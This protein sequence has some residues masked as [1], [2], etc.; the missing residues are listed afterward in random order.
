[1]IPVNTPLFSGN[2]EIYLRECIQTGWVS[3]E[4]P[5]VKQFEEKFASYIGVKHGISVCNGTAA[6]EV[7]LDSIG[8]TAGD[9]VIMPSSTIMSCALACIRLGA[10]PVISDVDKSTFT[11]TADLIKP[12]I[13]SKTKAL[14][15]VHLFGHPVDMDP[16]IDLAA[17]Y[18]LKILED[19]AEAHGAQ[20]FS[21]KQNKWLK[22]GSMGDVATFSFYANK[23]IT[24]GEGGMVV[25][26]NDSYEDRLRNYRNLFFNKDERFRH[27]ELGYNFRLSNIQAA[28]GLAQLEQIESFLNRKINYFKL[29]KELLA[30]CSGVDLLPVKSWAKS[31]YWMYAVVLDP[32]RNKTA[33]DIIKALSKKKIGSRNFF[34][35]LHSQP[36]LLSKKLIRNFHCPN[37]EF[38]YKFGLYLPSGLGMQEEDIKTVCEE[39]NILL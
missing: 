21:Q 15:I 19:S 29:Y 38:G 14:L 33:N 11:I 26:N 20:Y 13:T 8:V 6:I 22:C 27:D 30:S 24:T 34:R 3:S 4:G 23:L 37:T 16:I 31:S 28:L 1:M 5:F 12:L 32:K 10:T 39:L 7:G 35:G 18:N 2:E 9:E 25:T 36:A 17:E